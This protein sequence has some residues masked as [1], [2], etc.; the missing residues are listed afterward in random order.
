LDHASTHYWF[1]MVSFGVAGFD[2]TIALVA[3]GW[4]L[5]GRRRR[6]VAIFLATAVVGTWVYAVV[7]SLT[8]GRLGA[9][10]S[11]LDHLQAGPARAVL[12]AAVLAVGTGWLLV[13]CRRGPG[14]VRPTRPQ[15]TTLSTVVLALALVLGWAADPG[16][17][18]G[19]VLSGHGHSFAMVATGQSLW[20]LCALWPVGIVVLAL[21]DGFPREVAL[22]FQDWW[23]RVAPHR[24]W[25]LN[26]VL[27]VVLLALAGDALGYLLGGRYLVLNTTG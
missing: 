14:H 16:F 21:A 12:E 23:D 10:R 3:F 6:T 8:I 7:L 17:I 20:V 19:V 22:R 4:F 18:G 24:F 2:P 25:A 13:R 1:G 15:Q 26:A 9:V 5:V 11:A 27:V